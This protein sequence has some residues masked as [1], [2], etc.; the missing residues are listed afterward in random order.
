MTR[1]THQTLSDGF[2]K[3]KELGGNIRWRAQAMRL[4]STKRPQA[5]PTQL[6]YGACEIAVV[7]LH[8]ADVVRSAQREFTARR[9]R[10]AS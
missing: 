3:T 2:V 6:R 5:M 9:D 7:V 4:I 10:L 8:K 1:F